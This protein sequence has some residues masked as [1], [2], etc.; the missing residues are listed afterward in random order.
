[1]AGH[2]KWKNIQNKK[3]KTDAARARVFTKLG[4]ELMVAAKDNPNIE[5]N[6][7]LKDAVA[8]AKAANMPTDNINRAIKKAAGELGGANYEDITYEGYGP[9]GTAFIVETLTDNKNRT[10]ATVRH[11]FDK[12]GGNLGTTG[13][14]TFMFNRKGQ[15]ILEVT[16]EIDLDELEMVAIEAGAE[17]IIRDEEEAIEIITEPEDYNAVAEALEEAGYKP[18]D[19]GI[20]MIPNISTKVDL[21]TA[22][23]TQK[24]IDLLEEDDDI[25]DVYHNTDFPEEFEG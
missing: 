23:K 3:N 11:A 4:K 1:M 18:I 19:S 7:R 10:A 15:F 14:V 22:E 16:D 17:D 21:E 13:S 2:S 8:K 25:K 9:G 6:S 5:T 12:V 24:L 20:N